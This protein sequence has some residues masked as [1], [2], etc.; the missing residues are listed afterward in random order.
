MLSTLRLALKEAL[1][2]KRL[3]K[4]LTMKIKTLLLLTLG[5]AVASVAFAED[6]TPWLD[7]AEHMPLG[8][9]NPAPLM[10]MQIRDGEGAPIPAEVTED[11]PL[12]VTANSDI[13]YDEAPA[14]SVDGHEFDQAEWID[15]R[16]IALWFVQDWSTNKSYLASQ[17]ENLAINQMVII[18]TTPTEIGAVTCHSSRKMRYVREDGRPKE[19]FANSSS[20]VKFKVRDITPPACGFEISLKNGVSG[21]LWPVENPPDCFPLPKTAMM[22]FNGDLFE[23]REEIRVVDGYELGANMII[24]SVH[25]C[26]KLK[27]DSVIKVKVIGDDNFKLNHDKLKYGV[28][29]G[30][31]TEP[32]PVSPENEGEIDFTK[33]L[34]PENPYLYLDASDMAGNRQLLFLPLIFE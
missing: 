3:Y 20:A 18:P 16:P 31:G 32:T 19:V 33:F 25:G 1:D 22:C 7:G 13:F 28:C 11:I 23:A 5:L 12:V 27:R 30:A 29:A 34:I 9:T 17:A 26:L 8:P 14:K 15:E 6:D 10:D 24:P 4:E 21:Q 2:A